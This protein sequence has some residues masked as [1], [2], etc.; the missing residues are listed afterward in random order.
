MPEV[1]LQPDTALFVEIILLA[2]VFVLAAIVRRVL[3]K[4]RFG[5]GFRVIHHFVEEGVRVEVE[6]CDVWV[7]KG[8]VVRER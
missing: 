2:Q 5:V 7:C 8:E 4:G 3:V 1:L 6:K